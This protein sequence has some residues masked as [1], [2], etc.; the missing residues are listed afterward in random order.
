MEN[1]VFIFVQYNLIWQFISNDD[2][3][4]KN[5]NQFFGNVIFFI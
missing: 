5:V 3:F 1:K 4:E 2:N